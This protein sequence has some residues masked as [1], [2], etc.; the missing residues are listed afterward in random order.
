MK[1]YFLRHGRAEERSE[2]QTD[3]ERRLTTEGIAEMNRVAEGLALI[4]EELDLIYSSPLPRALETATIAAEA[5]HVPPDRLV[6]TDKLA[7]G[8]PGLKEL[9]SLLEHAPAS[10]R[11]MLVGHEPD[12]SSLVMRLTG[13]TIEMKKAGIAFVEVN[14]LEPNSGILRWLIAPRQ[15]QLLSRHST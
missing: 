3:Y 12:F 7:S 2:R 4:I 1:L 13:A 8:V 11:V 5:L 14:N 6:V 10:H 15:L 9:Q